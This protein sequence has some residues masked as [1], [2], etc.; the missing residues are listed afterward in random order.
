MSDT[1]PDAPTQPDEPTTPTSLTDRPSPPSVLSPHKVAKT[2]ASDDV[3]AQLPSLRTN[4][5][6]SSPPHKNSS[7]NLASRATS[8]TPRAGGNSP[9]LLSSGLNRHKDDKSGDDNDER[10]IEKELPDEGASPQPPHNPNTFMADTD[11]GSMGNRS[12][13][14][15]R[16]PTA[17]ADPPPPLCFPPVTID[18][19][20]FPDEALFCAL[21]PCNRSRNPHRRNP[22]FEIPS[23]GFTDKPAR[24]TFQQ[25]E[26]NFPRP[27][28]DGKLAAAN[29]PPEF[30]E[31]LNEYRDDFLLVA[32]FLDGNHFIEAWGHENLSAGI[33]NVLVNGGIAEP[34]NFDIIPLVPHEAVRGGDLYAPPFVLALKLDCPGLGDRLVSIATFAATQDLSFYIFEYDPD[35]RTWTIALFT[36]TS[37]GGRTKNGNYLRWVMARHILEDPEVRKAFERATGSTDKRHI[38][39]RLLEFARMLDVVWNPHS[40]HWCVYAQPCTY[41]FDDWEAVHRTMRHTALHHKKSM[42]TFSPIAARPDQAPWCLMCK[43]DD[44]L[45]YG[46]YFTK[47]DPDAWWGTKDQIN[48]LVDSI[49]A[50]KTKAKAAQGRGGAPGPAPLRGNGRG[51][52]SSHGN[53]GG[54]SSETRGSDRGRGGAANRNCY[55][56]PSTCR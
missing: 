41:D 4:R 27:V 54:L 22:A 15:Q 39:A 35:L 44:H 3:P 20:I 55:T 33:A 48:R 32:P 26:G 1:A 34:D 30:V 8:P 47:E 28:I 13:D 21:P 16:S 36:V 18:N 25:S 11:Q 31:T 53:G 9:P 2:S 17:A 23:T 7:T 29:V 51:S 46:C 24:V 52:L 14:D 56:V 19:F 40:R 50:K 37:G 38:L 42:I 45:H 12:G 10:E 49:L 5:E 43:N 6:L